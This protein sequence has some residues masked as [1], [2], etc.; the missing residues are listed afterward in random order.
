MSTVIVKSQYTAAEL[1]AMLLTGLPT[2][3]VS[4]IALADRQNWSYTEVSGRGGLR[5]EYTPPAEVMELIRRAATKQL[6]ATITPQNMPAIAPQS[7][8][9]HTEAQNLTADARKGVLDALNA[10]M[11]RTG[12]PLKRA[13]KYLIDIARNGDAS[14]QLVAMLK[15]ARDGRGRSSDDGLPSD[16]SLTRFVEY[17][18]TASLVPKVRERDMNVPVW[19]K[20]FMSYYQ[21]PEK[22]TVEHAYKLFCQSYQGDLPS[23]HKVRRFL[24]KVGAVSVQ[25]GRMGSHELKTIK[26]FV[27]RAF[28]KLLPSDIYSADGHTFDAEVQHPMHGRPFRPEITSVVDVATRRVVGW[29]VDLAESA[30]AV[31]D[32]LRVSTM[33]GGVPAILYVDNGSG[34]V[35]QM[36]TDTATGL[37]ARLGTEMVN[38]LPYSSQ[39]RGVIERLHQTIWVKAAKEVPGYIGKDM[40]RQA[41]LQVFKLSRQAIAKKTGETTVMPLMP[42]DLFLQFCKEK[43]SEYNAA[44]HST[45][46]KIIDPTTG[47]RRH[48]SPDEAW[49]L[50]EENGFNAHRITDDEARPLFR[51]QVMRSVR[52]C[53]IE[54][55]TNRYYSAALEEFHGTEVRVGYDLHDP[56]LVWIYADDGRLICTAELDGNKVDYMPQSFVERARDK[57]AAGRERRLEVKLEEVRAEREGMPAL[58]VSHGISIQADIEQLRAKWA[59]QRETEQLLQV[60]SHK[61]IDVDCVKEAAPV[62]EPQDTPASNVVAIPETPQARFSKWLTLDQQLNEGGEHIEP[63]LK[64]W[65]QSYQM[66]SEFRMFYRRHQGQTGQENSTAATVLVMNN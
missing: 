49:Q 28:D 18:K 24:S 47:R 26:G 20:A 8:L 50:A 4:I 13:A 45:L 25:V 36:M 2:S 57:R 19:A 9:A 43:V 33:V 22:P 11:Q 48:M 34:Y 21:R 52:R 40:D 15:L 17:Q 30:L 41:K 32:A 14:P 37:M 5:R 38:S 44:P 10:V 53:E 3:K 61:V 1:A 59:Q 58:E 29:S 12:Y 54:L 35:N 65:H 64:H 66:S 16:R 7:S 42:W 46:P 6:A 60:V 55:F 27:R 31:L 51:P 62:E 39:A 63:R 23:I 56:H